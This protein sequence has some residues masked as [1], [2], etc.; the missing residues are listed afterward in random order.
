MSAF[1]KSSPAFDRAVM[2]S[3]NPSDIAEIARHYVEGTDPRALEPEPSAALPTASTPA[4]ETCVRVIYPHGNA[5]F[6][7]FGVSEAD[8]DAQEKK[9]REMYGQR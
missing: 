5:R 2:A 1:A 8:L 3:N 4:P 6:E 9:I 7:I